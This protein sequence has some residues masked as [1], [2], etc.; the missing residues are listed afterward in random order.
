MEIS[1][2]LFESVIRR[3]AP[4]RDAREGGLDGQVEEV[5][6]VRVAAAPSLVELVDS[7]FPESPARSL[8]SAGGVRVAVA[9]DVGPLSERRLDHR[10][11]VVAPVG[12]HEEQFGT[13]IDVALRM[14]KGLPEVPA[15]LRA[16]GVARREDGQAARL[17]EGGR[18]GDL[19]TLSRP[20]DPFECH[21]KPAGHNDGILAREERP[22]FRN[23]LGTPFVY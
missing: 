20:L 5:S 22:R 21:E 6:P 3:A 19:R 18:P 1:I 4:L 17:E 23:Y 12:H 10:L 15:E 2:F 8:I 11:Q 9:E 16:A 14:Q 7:L 13:R